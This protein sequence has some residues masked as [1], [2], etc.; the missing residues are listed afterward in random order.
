M[1]ALKFVGGLVAV[2]PVIA[3]ILDTSCSSVRCMQILQTPCL[4]GFTLSH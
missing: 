2:E 3:A 1:S 4:Q